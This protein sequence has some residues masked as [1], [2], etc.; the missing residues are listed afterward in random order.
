LRLARNEENGRTAIG[1]ILR[2]RKLKSWAALGMAS[3]HNDQ[4]SAPVDADPPRGIWML[5]G[6]ADIEAEA[7]ARLRAA[8]F[9]PGRLTKD[10]VSHSRRSSPRRRSIFGL[11][12]TAPPGLGIPTGSPP[13]SMW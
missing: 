1:A 11:E 6:T 2:T 9:D 13:G 7:S 4:R 12:G 8:V 3:R 10:G 5:V